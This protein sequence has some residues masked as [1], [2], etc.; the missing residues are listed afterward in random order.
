MAFRVARLLGENDAD[1]AHIFRS[2]KAFCNIRSRFVHGDRPNDKEEQR[3]TR[4][5]DL[6]DYVRRLLRAFVLRAASPAPTYKP[7]YFAE[8]LDED[9]LAIVSRAPTH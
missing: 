1:R 2:M 7:K 9:P 3:L 5:E 6:K 4:V 8:Q